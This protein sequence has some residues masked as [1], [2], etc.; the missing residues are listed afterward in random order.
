MDFKSIPVLRIFDIAEAKAFYLDYLGMSLDWEH[1][2]D[3]HSPVYMQVSRGPLV[4]HL[5][6]HYGDCS[7]GAKLFIHVS[8]LEALYAE[9]DEK[10][11]SYNRPCIDIAPWGDRNFTVIDPFSNK[12]LFNEI[13]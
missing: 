5:T 10:N 2:F 8:D 4:F 1:K 12:I 9:M 6:Q 13:R 11:H 3:D 7:P